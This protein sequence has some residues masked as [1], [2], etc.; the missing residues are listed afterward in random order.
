M[1]RVELSVTV[2]PVRVSC[3]PEIRC[4]WEP[5][6]FRVLSGC[7]CTLRGWVARVR[8]MII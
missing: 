8:I 3:L 5:L 4:V 1:V 2:K 7:P 6:N